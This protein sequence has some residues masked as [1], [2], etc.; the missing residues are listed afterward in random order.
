MDINSLLTKAVELNASDLHLSPDEAPIVRID[1][2]LKRLD[3]PKMPAKEL[4]EVLIGILGET[5]LAIFKDKMEVDFSYVIPNVA[6]FRV[7]IFVQ[8]K[9]AAGAF[10][11][12]PLALPTFEKL[13]LPEIF[14]DLCN[15]PNGLVI[16]TG[17]TGSGKS[18]TLAT[19]INYVNKESNKR[20]HIITIE[21]PIEFIY[22]SGNCLIQQ[23]E[24]GTETQSFSNALRAALRE[25]PDIILLG[26]MRDL[27]TIQLAL[28]AAET[29]HLV[30]TT[31]HTN[32]AAKS[33]DRI[34]D[35]FPAG[36]KEMIRVM[37][38]ESLQAVVAQSL[39][40]RPKGGRLAAHE[41]MICIPAIR[42]LIR[43]HK[44]PQIYSIIQTHQSLGMHT[45]EQHVA[46]LLRHRQILPPETQTTI[47]P[48]P[49]AG[50][51]PP[52]AE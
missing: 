20:K 17:P 21:D 34:I 16:I 4:K 41:I 43:E 23:R 47:K 48:K 24:L 14:K 28:T 26:E 30:L 27:E 44:V 1:G 50:I 36:E 42:N 35:A 45:M 12:I 31:M 15:F 10:R 22:E 38:A 51:R 29:G 19:M 3:H 32:S 37:M 13:E 5:Q 33:V 11:V 9:G 40:K 6:R 52:P 8:H 18:T 7:N 49:K 39:L 46:D 2:D 25:D